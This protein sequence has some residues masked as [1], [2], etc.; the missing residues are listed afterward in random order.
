MEHCSSLKE[1]G[2]EFHTVLLSYLF[3]AEDDHDR[4]SSSSETKDFTHRWFSH[5]RD[6]FAGLKR[7]FEIDNYPQDH[8]LNKLMHY[9]LCFSWSG[10][11]FLYPNFFDSL[12]EKFCNTVE[13]SVVYLTEDGGHSSSSKVALIYSLYRKTFQEKEFVAGFSDFLSTP[14]VR[15]N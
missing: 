10:L 13:N 9:F 2:S 6:S 8:V 14:E 11:S 12:K 1:V 7:R 3:L 4:E 5:L 15:S